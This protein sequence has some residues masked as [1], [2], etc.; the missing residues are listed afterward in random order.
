MVKK[1]ESQT[2]TFFVIVLYNKYGKKIYKCPNCSLI[3]GTLAPENPSNT[4]YFTHC[5]NCPNKNK[6]PIE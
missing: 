5:Y 6:I 2:G 4:Y 3:T 1:D